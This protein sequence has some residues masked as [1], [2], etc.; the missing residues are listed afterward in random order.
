MA[1]G[2]E[3]RGAER[4]SPPRLTRCGGDQSGFLNSGTYRSYVRDTSLNDSDSSLG[5]CELDKSLETTG[6]NRQAIRL[7]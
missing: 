4:K 7:A 2:C 3:G 5:I 1:L 6:R